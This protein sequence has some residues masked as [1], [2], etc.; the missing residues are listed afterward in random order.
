MQNILKRIT[1]RM[2]GLAAVFVA[3][4]GFL[5]LH[6]DRA[7]AAKPPAA[8]PAIPVTVQTINP[9]SV[10]IWS[11]F[12]GRLHAVDYAEIRPQASGRI[13]EVKFKD[14][15]D[16]KAGDVLF[17]IDPRP[18]EAAVA[19]A[20]ASLASAK[21]NANFNKTD[22]A[23]A[24]NMMKTQAIARRV[25]DERVNADKVARAAIRSAEAEVKQ[26][27][28]DLDHA[29]VKA[30]ISG[31]VSRAE[32]TVGNLVQTGPNAPLLTSIVSNNGI[33]ADFEVD[34]QT[35][36]K[37]IRKDAGTAEQEQAI[38]VEL[39][40]PGDTKQVFK[41]TIYSFD[42]HIDTNSGTIRARAKFENDP[43]LVPGMFVSVK[44]GSS[45]DNT[46]LLIPDRAIGNDQNKKFVF[47]VDDKN[48]VVYRDVTLGEAVNG[49]RI[50]VSGLQAGERVIVDGLQHVKPDAVVD[51][52]EAEAAA[53]TPADPAPDNA[54][55]PPA[56]SGTDQPAAK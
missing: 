47:V 45:S 9:Q 41:G 25:Y 50:V 24:S 52:K 11:P 40:L 35:Y 16:V 44:L 55:P 26:A 42:N 39:T 22:L 12:S 1:P 49:Q 10:R 51:P 32:I 13:M 28:V 53:L 36:L 8:P 48:K 29:Y 19:K 34:E 38:P 46:V 3:A 5:I 2:L 15:Q 6:D 20:E 56:A 31:R 14:G 7:D 37:S 54:L 18:Y 30:P 23:R 21:T 17:V 43:S 27:Q 4:I 33:Y